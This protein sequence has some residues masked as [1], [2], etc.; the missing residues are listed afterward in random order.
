[1]KKKRNREQLSCTISKFQALFIEI[2]HYLSTSFAMFWTL[3]ATFSAQSE[4]AYL[5]GLQP[6]LSGLFVNFVSLI[7]I[8][9]IKLF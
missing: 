3:L 9:R 7:M 1:M 8:I 5:R 2:E 4:Q 6:T